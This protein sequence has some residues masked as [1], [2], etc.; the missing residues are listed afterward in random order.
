MWRFQ[1]MFWSIKW[2]SWTVKELNMILPAAKDKESS[3]SS[4]WKWGIHELTGCCYQQWGGRARAGS[5]IRTYQSEDANYN[6]LAGRRVCLFLT[7]VTE[8]L[9]QASVQA[10][11]WKDGT[12][13]QG[14]MSDCCCAADL[15]DL[16]EY[17]RVEA[18]KNGMQQIQMNKELACYNAVKM[19]LMFNLIKNGWSSQRAQADPNLSPFS[20]AW[21]GQNTSRESV[22][23]HLWQHLCSKHLFVPVSHIHQH[24]THL[25]PVIVWKTPK[26]PQKRYTVHEHRKPERQQHNKRSEGTAALT[27]TTKHNTASEQFWSP[28]LSGSFCDVMCKC[29]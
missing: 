9:L 20:A 16:K 23:S 13:D 18:E 4:Q 19:L 24:A 11:W 5:K 22:L 6:L 2:N 29:C 8:A 7:K 21:D 27:N 3:H 15:G 28:W 12:W 14:D 1:G 26:K 17:F 25:G 10:S